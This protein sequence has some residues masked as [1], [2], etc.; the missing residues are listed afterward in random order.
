LNTE[1]LANKAFW[2]EKWTRNSDEEP[3]WDLQGPHPLLG[4]L[5]KMIDETSVLKPKSNIYVPGCGRAHNAAHFAS[6]GHRVLAMDIVPEAITRAKTLYQS[7][8]NLSFVLGSVF[9]VA[10]SDEGQT[11]LIF[12]RAMLC[13]L[14][15]TRRPQF[16]DAM[17][18]RL[19]TGGLFASIGFAKTGEQVGGPPFAIGIDKI[20]E[21]FSEKFTLVSA[22]QRQDGSCD[23]V[24]LEEIL[25]IWR[26]K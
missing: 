14:D 9:D 5:I 10:N 25:N 1:Q 3:K 18:L 6:L 4:E 8:E 13:A 23:D 11:D 7:V 2:Q 22:E 17:A 24:I 16:V 15:E 19:R 21:L 20:S 26:K 12:D